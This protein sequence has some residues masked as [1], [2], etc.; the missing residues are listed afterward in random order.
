MLDQGPELVLYVFPSSSS[1]LTLGH[2]W[3]TETIA[4]SQGYYGTQ[5]VPT[6]V[7]K[8]PSDAMAQIELWC[9]VE[10]LPW[11]HRKGAPWIFEVPGI[12]RPILESSQTMTC[13]IV[14]SHGRLSW[15]IFTRGVVLKI[16]C[17][18]IRADALVSHM[19]IWKPQSSNGSTIVHPWHGYI[20]GTYLAWLSTTTDTL[21]FLTARKITKPSSPN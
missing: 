20:I 1:V 8:Q 21:T 14:G 19:T 7:D 4:I 2:E 5:D 17:L 15:M 6:F 10:V 11:W 12:G 16:G 3:L 13:N 18:V 9:R